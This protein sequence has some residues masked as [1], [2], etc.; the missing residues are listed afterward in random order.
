MDAIGIDAYWPVSDWRDGA[1][2]KDLEYSR[3]LYDVAY[4]AK[5]MQSGEAYDWYYPS[6]ADRVA[7]N[8]VPIT[9][10]AYQKPWVWRGKDLYGWW[11]NL[12]IERVDGIEL[13]HATP[14][15]P[16]SK[17]IWLTEVGCP[18]VDKGANMPN[19]FPD[20]KSAQASLPFGSSGADDDLMLLR[21][22][23]A[24]LAAF[25]V[26][27]GAGAPANPLAP[28]GKT[29]MIDADHIAFWSYDARPFPAFPHLRS[30]WSDGASYHT[31]HWL[32][33]RLEMVPVDL[34][35]RAMLDDYGLPL[36]LQTHCHAVID[37]F[38]IDRTLSL[39]A[40]FAPLA[41]LF[42][43]DVVAAPEGILCRDR[44]RGLAASLQL[45]DMVPFSSGD[46]VMLVRA[47]PSDVPNQ[48]GLIYSDF[49]LDYRRALVSA[50]RLAGGGRRQ[51]LSDQALVMKRAQAQVWADHWLQDRALA[52][53]SI[54][55]QLGLLGKGLEAGDLVSLPVGDVERIFLITGVQEGL[56]RRFKA[57]AV[58]PQMRVATSGALN[59]TQARAPL[60]A[61]RPWVEIFD[62][63]YASGKPETVQAIAV[64]ADPWPGRLTVWQSVDGKSYT[65]AT[66]I[67]SC[68]R[69]GRTVSVLRSGPLWV[70][71]D[72]NSLSFTLA[73]GVLSSPGDL[74][75]LAG[76]LVLLVKAPDG[77]CELIAFAR[78]ELIGAGQWR[79]S[80]LLRGLGGTEAQAQNELP[81]GSLVVVLDG[82]VQPLLQG[83]T[84]VGETWFW[85]IA[86]AN[87]D[88][89][90]SLSVATTTTATAQALL[91][92]APVGLVAKRRSDGIAISWI[93]RARL[94][95]DSWAEADIALDEAVEAYRVSVMKDGVVM[96]QIEVN[97][98]ACLY[99]AE[100]EWSDFGARQTGLALTVQQISASVGAGRGLSVTVPLV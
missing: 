47:P 50:R 25:D 18:A 37:G 3:T 9:D 80:R 30:V 85:R 7:Q 100:D 41:D 20:A 74:A 58:D 10:G 57:R 68:A 8:R 65:P 53:E 88:P 2:H 39:D 31:G 16:F 79:V 33:G 4:L 22:I 6:L 84:H 73:G 66:V 55:F 72:A 71:D 99:R 60:V 97:S 96:R 34:L 12:H 13:S 82:A 11:S 28:D 38:V 48:L 81:A 86:P 42:A 40:A 95:A 77:R 83:A 27:A 92:M 29:R 43:L 21:Y 14:W 15:Q 69:M 94:A 75:A 24:V 54:E 49:D 70:W 26:Q 32:N 17:P 51:A 36:P 5:R 93:R 61:G 67:G 19:L 1:E 56:V 87:A 52:I 35:L 23:Q 45:D 76:Q 46:L 78:A 91:P 98:P 63:P 90:G 89:Y 44:L 64:C 59:P 62:L